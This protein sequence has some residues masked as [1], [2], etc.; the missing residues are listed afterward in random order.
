MFKTIWKIQTAP[1]T[2]PVH[3]A[4]KQKQRRIKQGKRTW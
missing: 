3:L 4:K 1:F 2:V